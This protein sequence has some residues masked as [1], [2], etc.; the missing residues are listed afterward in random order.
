MSQ[1]ENGDVHILYRPVGLGEAVRILDAGSLGFPPRRPEQPIFYPVLN[2]EYAEQIAQRWNASNASTGYAGFVTQFLLDRT[3]AAQ[4]T[5]H[6]VGSA[7]HSEYWVPAEQLAEFNEHLLGSIVFV[8]AHYGDG[9]V[10][11]TPR[12]THLKGLAAREQ[13]PRL[14]RI[15][16]ENGWDFGIEVRRQQLAVPLNF[17]YWVRT[18]L[19][20]EGLTF[21]RKVTTLQAVQYAWND[22]YPEVKLIGSDELQALADKGAT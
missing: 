9:Y 6:V 10:G 7:I 12:P 5:P 19:T 13:L 2:R 17:A 1:P 8:S 11:P 22:G 21:A 14:E 20:A 15:L 4:F 18:D 3:Y 16:E